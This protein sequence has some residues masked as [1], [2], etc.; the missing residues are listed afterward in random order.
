MANTNTC[1]TSKIKMPK[2]YEAFFNFFIADDAKRLVLLPKGMSGTDAAVLCHVADG[3]CNEAGITCIQ[4]DDNPDATTSVIDEFVQNLGDSFDPSQN[5]VSIL[6]FDVNNVNYVHIAELSTDAHRIFTTFVPCDCED[7]YEDDDYDGADRVVI[8]PN[9]TAAKCIIV[10]DWHTAGSAVREIGKYL[11]TFIEK[12][13]IHKDIA[14]AVKKFIKTHKHDDVGNG[15][16]RSDFARF[17]YYEASILDDMETMRNTPLRIMLKSSVVHSL[18]YNWCEHNGQLD[19]Y[20]TTMTGRILNGE[21]YTDPKFAKYFRHSSNSRDND[22][23]FAE[24]KSQLANLEPSEFEEYLEN[25]LQF[26]F[27]SFVQGYL[28]IIDSMVCVSTGNL[29]YANV[30]GLKLQLNAPSVVMYDGDPTTPVPYEDAIIEYIAKHVHAVNPTAS[31][32]KHP[33]Y[34]LNKTMSKRIIPLRTARGKLVTDGGTKS[35]S[36]VIKHHTGDRDIIKVW[37]FE[38]ATGTPVN[39]TIRDSLWMA[40]SKDG[41]STVTDIEGNHLYMLP[42][43]TGT[44]IDLENQ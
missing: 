44:V 40:L 24:F 25:A 43:Y 1:T 6:V 27:G 26:E 20:I 12:Y 11:A 29:T 31:K 10:P 41:T 21:L 15:E 5:Y 23:K 42:N 34:L 22:I 37:A 14:H 8:L 7:D 19:K 2:S 9:G 30:V 3:L 13:D 35:I 28:N 16:M 18:F 36:L 4:V 32:T 39:R 17:G 38:P 33:P